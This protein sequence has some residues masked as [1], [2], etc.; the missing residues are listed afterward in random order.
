MNAHTLAATAVVASTGNL[1][2]LLIWLIVVGLIFTV[3]WWA[4]GQIAIAEPFNKIIRVIVVLICAI[5]L[6]NLLL[7][8]LGHPLV[9]F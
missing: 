2:N 1:G 4:L 8:L 9:T 6:I 5:V 3:V 7:G